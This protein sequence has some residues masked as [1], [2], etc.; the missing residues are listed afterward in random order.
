MHAAEEGRA[1]GEAEAHE[2]LGIHVGEG[3]QRRYLRRFPPRLGG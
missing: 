1:H 3:E 2:Q